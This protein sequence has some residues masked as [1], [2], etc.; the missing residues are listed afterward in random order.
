MTAQP[1]ARGFAPAGWLRIVAGTWPD[2]K[3]GASSL[4]TVAAI[5][6]AFDDPGQNGLSV[7]VFWLFCNHDMQGSVDELRQFQKSPNFGSF[8]FFVFNREAGLAQI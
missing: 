6:F 5:L 4:P 8:D 1:A 7:S 3:S 2:R